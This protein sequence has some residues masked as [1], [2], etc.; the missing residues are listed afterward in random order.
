MFI[1]GSLFSGLIAIACLVGGI[2]AIF[3]QREKRKQG[4]YTSGSII[5]LEK[6]VLQPGSS[7]VYCPVVEF[8]DA[9]GETHHF[10]SAFGTLPASNKVGDTV[11]IFYNPDHPD[12]AEIE[13]GISK[14]FAPGCLLIFAIGACFFSLMFLG[15]FFLYQH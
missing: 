5:G 8:S 10:E 9:N 15:L 6:R 2:Y 12:E 7:G 11:K 4:V 1:V 13:S 14:Y 3:T